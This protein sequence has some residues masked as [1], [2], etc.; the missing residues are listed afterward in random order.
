MARSSARCSLCG[1]PVQ[2]R[3]TGRGAARLAVQ[4]GG[5]GLTAT[6]LTGTRLTGTRLAGLGHRRVR[7]LD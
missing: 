3:V 2:G 6:G 4:W 1:R 5:T 7:R